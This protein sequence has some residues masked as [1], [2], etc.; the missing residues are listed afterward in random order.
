MK[1]TSN[2]EEIF[3]IREEFE[4]SSPRM[5][6]AIFNLR[7]G[8]SANN[9]SVDKLRAQITDLREARELLEDELLQRSKIIDE[10]SRELEN[11][12]N[13]AND[14][15]L[16]VAQ[17]KSNAK[18]SEAE[19][20]RLSSIISEDVAKRKDIHHAL[21]NADNAIALMSEQMAKTTAELAEANTRLLEIQAERIAEANAHIKYVE[22][23]SWELSQAQLQRERV[24]HYRR[25]ITQ[26]TDEN[27]RLKAQAEARW[28]LRRPYAIAQTIREKLMLRGQKSASN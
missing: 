6:Q 12:A 11:W 24:D 27:L 3:A 14:D 18:S 1:P 10:Q 25:T 17:L 5:A 26:L 22:N 16:E 9:N 4:H 19:I 23:T 28:L 21:A 20:A 13:S 15:K 2:S 8:L 7:G